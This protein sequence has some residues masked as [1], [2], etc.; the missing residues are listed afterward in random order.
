MFLATDTLL[1]VAAIIGSLG[2]FVAAI[3]GLI[4]SMAN[5][6]ALRTDN[7]LTVGQMTQHGYSMEAQKVPPAV[8][9]EEQKAAVAMLTEQEHATHAEQ[10]GNR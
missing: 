6:K 9:T 10:E 5:R 7:G 8:R 2:T 1:G 3:A 4:V